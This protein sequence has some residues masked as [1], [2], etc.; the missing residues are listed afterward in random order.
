MGAASIIPCPSALLTLPCTCT[1]S[2]CFQAFPPA[3]PGQTRFV[4]SMPSLPSSEDEDNLKVELQ[5][6]KTVEVDGGNRFFFGGRLE[7]ENIA[8]WGFTRYVLPALGPMAGTL[9]AVDPDQPKVQRFVRIGG[10]PQ[11]MRYNSRLPYVVYVPE[12]VEVRYKYWRADAKVTSAE[13]G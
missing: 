6:G 9:M 2:P 8:G 13:R 10:E 11:L 1:P 12:G 3:E 4:I 7:K 5:V